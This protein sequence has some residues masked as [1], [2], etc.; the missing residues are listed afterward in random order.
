MKLIS[1]FTALCFMSGIAYAAEPQ[2]FETKYSASLYG[3][4]LDITS[5]LKKLSNGKYQ[6]YNHVDSYAGELIETSQLTWTETNKLVTPLAYK[7]YWS[8]LGKSS[9]EQVRFDWAKR[10]ATSTAKNTSISLQGIAN[11]QDNLSYQL[12]M[13]QDFIA[14][15]KSVSYNVTDGQKNSAFVFEIVKEEIIDS[16]LGKVKAVK[17]K[18]IQSGTKETYVWLAKDYQYLLV[19]F[20]QRKDGFL[21]TFTLNKAALNGKPI[22]RF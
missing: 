6:L 8:A 17:V 13:R 18:R 11:I 19:K 4:N 9:D 12:Q 1:L 14:G 10:T 2:I 16:A 22:Q 15:K 5:N 7:K 3:Y 20:E 21:Y